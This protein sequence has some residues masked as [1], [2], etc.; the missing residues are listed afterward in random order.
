MYVQVRVYVAINCV[1]HD[2]RQ[3]QQVMVYVTVVRGQ[4]LYCAAPVYEK[5]TD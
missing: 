3:Q 1:E 5:R 2:V 4:L